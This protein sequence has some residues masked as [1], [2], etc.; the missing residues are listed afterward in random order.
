MKKVKFK[1]V[2]F[3][4]FLLVLTVFVAVFSPLLK[5]SDSDDMNYIYSTFIGK[6]SEYNGV[7]EVWNIDSFES[8]TM[9]KVS[10]LEKFA[11]KFQKENKGIYIVVRNLTES[12]M[13]NL[14]E[15]NQVPDVISCSYGVADKIKDYVCEISKLPRKM[16]T[17]FADAGKLN[18]KQYGLAWCTGFYSLISTKA[19][20]EKAGKDVSELNNIKLNEIAF[21]SGYE[22]KSG[23]HIKK[24]ISLV[25]GEGNYLMPKSALFAYNRAGSI[26][27][28]NDSENEL[29][30]KSQYSAY[31]SFLSNGATILLGTHR[32]I[33]RME[34]RVESGKVSDVII[35]PI[36][37]WT[38]LVQFAFVCKQEN[39]LRKKYAE[40][41][42]LYL[43]EER[44]Q[45]QVETIGMFPILAMNETDYKGIMRDI[46]LE[47]FSD[48]ELKKIFG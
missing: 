23:K 9:S 38:D 24:S 18:G 30:F 12:E 32:D 20:L 35:Q 45:K 28:T 13:V 47:N 17:N 44:N 46:I 8:G 5:F 3:R 27:S 39:S 26:Q 16:P 6:K 40:M 4:L 43:L 25:Y 21:S 42:V 36:L 10:L 34:N 41:F 11:K 33:I 2:F 14:L 15:S 48:C 19:K 37:S 22:Y 7:L 29:V 1:S 31:S